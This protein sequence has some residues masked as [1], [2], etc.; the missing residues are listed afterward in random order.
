[1]MTTSTVALYTGLTPRWLAYLGY[2]M[3][4]LLLFGSYFINWGFIIFPLWALLTSI[5]IL[6]DN[7]RGRPI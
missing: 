6:F 2:A 3:S 1:M 7:I 4:L 5:R